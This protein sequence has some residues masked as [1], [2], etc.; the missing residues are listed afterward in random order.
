[1]CADWK[2]ESGT[3]RETVIELAKAVNADIAETLNKAG[4]DVPKTEKSQSG[5]ILPRELAI[6]DFDGFD[7]QDLKEIADFINFKRSQ[8]SK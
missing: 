8:M 4:F 5:P 6:M 7:D 1:M 3:K 2:S